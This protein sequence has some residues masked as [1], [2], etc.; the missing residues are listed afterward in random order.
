MPGIGKSA[1]LRHTVE[2]Q[3]PTCA[4][5]QR[6]GVEAEAEYPF[7]GCTGC[8]SRSSTGWSGLPPTQR[9]AL[10]VACGLADGPPADTFLVGLAALSLL[11]ELAA[12]APLLLCRRR[13]AVARPESL[14]AS[15]SWRGGS[16]PRARA[17][18]RGAA[19]DPTTCPTSTGC[20]A[21][22]ITRARRRQRASSSSLTVVDTPLD[23]RASPS[24]SSRPPP[25]TRSRSPTSA[26]SCSAAQLGGGHPCPARS[27]SAASSRP[28]T[29][30]TGARPPDATQ[31]WLALAA[32]EPTGDPGDVAAAAAR[33]AIDDDRE[34]RRRGGRAS[35]RSAHGVA[36]RHPLVRSAIY[37]GATSATRRTV[38]RGARRRRPPGHE[39]IDRRA[40]HLAAACI[41]AD[42]EVAAELERVGPRAADQRRLRGE[43][44]LLAARRAHSRPV[45]AAR[46]AARSPP[47]SAASSGGRP[48]PSRLAA[49]PG[50]TATGSHDR[51]GPRCSCSAAD[52]RR[53][54]RRTR[55][56]SRGAGR[57]PAP[58]RG[59]SPIESPP[60]RRSRCF[61]RGP[62][63]DQRRAP[64]DRDHV[65]PRSR[66]RS[67]RRWS[68]DPS[69]VRTDA[70]R[71]RRARDRRLRSRGPPPARRR[72]AL[73]EPSDPR[74]RSC[75]RAPA[76]VTFC[77]MLT[78]DLDAAAMPLLARDERARPRAVGA[79]ARPRH[80]P[81]L[82]GD[83]GDDLRR[84]RSSADRFLL[85]GNQMRSALG[86]TPDADGRSTAIPSSLAWR[87]G[88]DDL[89][90]TFDGHIERQPSC[91]AT[92]PWSPSPT[93]RSVI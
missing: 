20:P 53:A 5:A 72:R 36:F 71:L 19:P 59:C 51:S 92:A 22:E 43:R 81:V 62:P 12:R 11:A 14:V 67:A 6:R 13:R 80:H 49:R 10:R 61:A 18:V 58:R 2:R 73:L 31:S 56:R 82:P 41:G 47:P 40:W 88:R 29:C 46:P 65:W 38:P 90:D 70:R 42:D 1:L 28:T 79:P 16:T 39:D 60:G 52:D 3:P 64:R 21:L 50:S 27:R 15:P 87:S 91:S 45:T 57:C 55:Q 83:G 23:P 30:A 8:S 44:D 7:A 48:P 85:E 69:T 77:T 9:D 93:S 33:L 89:A 63:R 17:P 75:S 4:R 78:W 76:G 24:R 84:P 74:R 68:S 25:A 66:A 54:D 34:R 26:R 86:A 32:A 35:S 37:G